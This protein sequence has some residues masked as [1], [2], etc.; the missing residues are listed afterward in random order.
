MQDDIEEEAPFP[1]QFVLKAEGYPVQDTG[2]RKARRQP[3]RN[4]LKSQADKPKGA[5][6]PAGIA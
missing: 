3:C 4:C 6:Q 1:N 5:S 2:E